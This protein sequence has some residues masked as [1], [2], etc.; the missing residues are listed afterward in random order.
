[1]MLPWAVGPLSNRAP[2]YQD[3]YTLVNRDGR[4]RY[5]ALSRRILALPPEVLG[6]IFFF[7]LRFDK[8][9]LVTPHLDDAPLV[10]C[11]VCRQWRSVVLST[12]KLW[13]SIFFESHLLNTERYT[14]QSAALYIDFCHE[15]LFRA[16]NTP[17][18]I[19][20]DANDVCLDTPNEL[21]DIIS[22]LSQQWQNIEIRGDLP[23][24]HPVHG[25]YPFLEKLKIFSRSSDHP[26]VR[27]CLSTM[28]RNYATFFSRINIQPGYSFLG[29]R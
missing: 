25:N 15:W 5:S 9:L 20:L 19:C 29:T 26:I 21:V 11:V 3:Q 4:L 18:S 1:M 16:R 28:H 13:N 8:D 23:L 6:E 27:Y 22:E 14:P 7:C 2:E 12:P 24:S 17:L 10:L